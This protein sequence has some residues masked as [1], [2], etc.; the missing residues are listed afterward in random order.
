[1]GRRPGTGPCSPFAAKRGT[2]ELQDTAH[3]KARAAAKWEVVVSGSSNVRIASP[4]RVPALYSSVSIYYAVEM[5]WESLCILNQPSGDAMEIQW[6]CNGCQSI[7]LEIQSHVERRLVGNEI[8]DRGQ[9]TAQSIGHDPLFRKV[10]I[11]AE[12]A[13]YRNGCRNAIFREA[14]RLSDGHFRLRRRLLAQRQDAGL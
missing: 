9:W 11:N 12:Y 5:Q 4:I 2:A 13:S 8:H 1:M 6:R 3:A 10:E 7:H 14:R